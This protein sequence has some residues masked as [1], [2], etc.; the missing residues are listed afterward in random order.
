[1]SYPVGN[2]VSGL[3]NIWSEGAF[4]PEQ[5]VSFIRDNQTPINK[6]SL[7]NSVGHH[8]SLI[9]N[10]INTSYLA[11]ADYPINSGWINNIYNNFI[12]TDNINMSGSITMNVKNSDQGIIAYYDEADKYTFTS[13]LKPNNIS[14]TQNPWNN[15][16]YWGKTTITPGVITVCGAKNS[17]I[18]A[19]GSVMHFNSDTF[20]TLNFNSHAHV[21]SDNKIF[22]YIDTTFR[23]SSA[24]IHTEVK[25]DSITSTSACGFFITNTNKIKLKSKLLDMSAG[26][27]LTNYLGNYDYPIVNS[28]MSKVIIT[29]S[30]QMGTNPNSKFKI[31]VYKKNL[32]GSTTS[33]I[34]LS[35]TVE[36]D[37][38]DFDS[39]IATAIFNNQLITAGF[40]ITGGD[41]DDWTVYPCTGYTISTDSSTGVV[42]ISVTGS[43]AGMAS[44]TNT[45]VSMF[46]IYFSE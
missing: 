45:Y 32:S 43:F 26:T 2:P 27:V 21:I 11:R 19:S 20:A 5:V 34:V 7:I 22:S 39:V 29:D 28:Y 16:D 4:T 6:A 38:G 46:F 36:N 24:G 8:V 23:V 30:L 35:G 41:L 12:Q 15:S 14:L 3:Y 44:T 1:M 25:P 31:G 42:N 10:F 9:E 18:T 40:E 37:Y 17:G 13:S 33:P